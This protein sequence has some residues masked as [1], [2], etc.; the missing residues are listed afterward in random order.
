MNDH[1]DRGLGGRQYG[2]PQEIETLV[3]SR[4][5]DPLTSGSMPAHAVGARATPVTERSRNMSFH[6]LAPEPLVGRLTWVLVLPVVRGALS[7]STRRKFCSSMAE[8]HS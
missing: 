4:R 8:V 1:V 7:P 5:V 6:S 2:T 3:K